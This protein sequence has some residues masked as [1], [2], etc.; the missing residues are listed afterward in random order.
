M[1]SPGVGLGPGRQQRGG[2]QEPRPRRRE[3]SVPSTPQAQPQREPST[4][5]GP[6]EATLPSTPQAQ[7]SIIFGPLSASPP[8]KL[9]WFTGVEGIHRT[10]RRDGS[11]HALAVRALLKPARFSAPKSGG[12]SRSW[13]P[14]QQLPEN[15]LRFSRTH[16]H[17]VFPRFVCA[18]YTA[19]SLSQ[20]SP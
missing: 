11:S 9:L 4:P 1:G 19:F 14:F 16:T 12:P 3:L 20:V 7:T 10:G 18:A 13:L 2:V 17:T 5:Q 8:R 6:A 15:R